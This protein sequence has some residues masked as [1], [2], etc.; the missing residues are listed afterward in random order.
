MDNGEGGGDKDGDNG[1]IAG[2]AV[3]GSREVFVIIW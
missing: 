3:Q 1:V 2:C